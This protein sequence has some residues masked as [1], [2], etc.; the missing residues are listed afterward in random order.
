MCGMLADLW[1][2]YGL[3]VATPRLQLRLLR[4]SELA[5]L[6][7]LAGRGVHRPGERPFL[8]PW[9]EGSPADRASFGLSETGER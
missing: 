1:P 9:T 8:T 6:A 4:E 7:D 5:E 3:T 2:Q